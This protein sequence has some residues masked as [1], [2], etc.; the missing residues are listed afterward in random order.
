LSELEIRNWLRSVGFTPE[1]DGRSWLAGG[2][3][4]GRLHPTEIVDV[5]LA[6]RSAAG[7]S[8]SAG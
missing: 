7:P 2:D 8:A 4:L 5:A 6:F 1:A 3:C